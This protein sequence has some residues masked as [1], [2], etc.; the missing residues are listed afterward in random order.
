[1]SSDLELLKIDKKIID[2]NRYFLKFI[3]NFF[4]TKFGIINKKN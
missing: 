4:T 2:A 1:M 3:I